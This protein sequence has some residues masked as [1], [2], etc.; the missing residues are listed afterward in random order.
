MKEREVIVDSKGNIEADLPIAVID[1]SY[2]LSA[3]LASYTENE[4]SAAKDFLQD[5]IEKNGQIIVPQLFWFEVGNVLLNAVKNDSKGNLGRITKA[6]LD[7]ILMTIS[8]LPIYT[9]LQ[10][11]SEIRT[12]ILSTALDTGLTYYDAAYLELARRKDVP[13]KT[14]DKPLDAAWKKG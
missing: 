9:D 10:P 12:R 2:F 6:E 14:W 1:T 13:L 11:D 5:L 8:A 3:I 4:S 7:E